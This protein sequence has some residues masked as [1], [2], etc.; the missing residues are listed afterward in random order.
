MIGFRRKGFHRT[1]IGVSATALLVFSCSHRPGSISEADT[2]QRMCGVGDN[3]SLSEDHAFCIAVRTGMD[4]LPCKDEA[5]TFE[6]ERR[7]VW[8]VHND[9]GSIGA[10]PTGDQ[11]IIVTPGGRIRVMSIRSGTS[12]RHEGDTGNRC[13]PSRVVRPA[14]SAAQLCGV[15]PTEIVSRAE[16]ICIAG[17]LG[18]ADTVCPW[19]IRAGDEYG[20]DSWVVDNT[21]GDY[22]R[23][24]ARCCGVFFSISRVG[25]RLLS[26]GNLDLNCE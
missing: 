21:G 26:V 12:K 16:A 15:R 1:M 2:I 7:T 8:S 10:N 4:P 25:G 22:G 17:R 18:M 13:W 5:E 19:S 23:R 24:D 9:S 11:V 20:G 3:D 14:R 6:F